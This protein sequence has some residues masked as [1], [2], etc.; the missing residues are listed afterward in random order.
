M[1]RSTS[2]LGVLGT[3]QATWAVYGIGLVAVGAFFFFRPA[4]W[5]AASEWDYIL[6]ILG[7]IAAAGLSFA[8]GRTWP[9]V[10]LACE[11]RWLASLPFEVHGYCEA[12]ARTPEPDPRYYLRVSLPGAALDEDELRALWSRTCSSDAAGLVVKDGDS[13]GIW[14]ARRYVDARAWF[15]TNLGLHRWF[16]RTVSRFLRALH[17]RH[18]IARVEVLPWDA[19]RSAG[20]GTLFDLMR[21]AADAATHRREEAAKARPTRRPRV[22]AVLS[23][24]LAS[25]L[26]GP[27]GL[28]GLFTPPLV[29][30]PLLSPEDQMD[31]VLMIKLVAGAATIVLL[32]VVG[33]WLGYART[34]RWLASLPY[35][36]EGLFDVLGR[37]ARDAGPNT[38]RLAFA[39][40]APSE[41]QVRAALPP[42][43]RAWEV[44]VL[45]T[46]CVVAVQVESTGF[47]GNPMCSTNHAYYRWFRALMT[48]TV[49]ALHRTSPVQRVSV[50]TGDATKP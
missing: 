48:R 37:D 45:A 1:A 3:A 11:R 40:P 19:E 27:L 25:Y 29:L 8:L 42:A 4:E 5:E 39:G 36:V 14:R 43:P 38:V 44:T 22:R 21:A 32:A 20:T 41:E 7:Y 47:L 17:A 9:R 6:P 16:R 13:L 10:T 12:L 26:L 15:D 28:A 23:T 24:S 31:W 33:C 18:P 30:S 46:D 34:K 50:D 49:A 35:P 2:W